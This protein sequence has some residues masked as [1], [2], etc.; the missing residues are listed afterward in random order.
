MKKALLRIFALTL[1][2][3]A[4]MSLAAC[5]ILGG[6]EETPG[7]NSGENSGEQGGNTEN[8]GDNTGNEETPDAHEHS[9]GEW[10]NAD[11]DNHKKTCECGDVQTE[12]HAWA[13]SG[14]TDAT[15]T[16]EGSVSYACACGATKSEALDKTPEH[17]YGEWVNADADNHKQTCECG[18]VQTEAHAWAESG[19]T[20]A[21]HTAEGSVSYACA[22]GATK[23]EALD[24][25]PE[26]S[27][28][29]WVNADEDNH[30]Q[31]CECG[32]V[33]TEAHTWAETDRT[34]ATHTAEGRVSYA[35]ACGATKSETL[36]K[37]PEHSYGEFE[38]L[39]AEN[40]KKTCECGDIQTEA[41]ELNVNDEC[42][43][44]YA[45]E[46]THK[47]ATTI[48]YNA[49]GHWY[50]SL[51]SKD[52]SCAIKKD[53]AAHDFAD[54]T[55]CSC[56]YAK[57]QRG[58]GDYANAG[59]NYTG[60]TVTDL[61]GAGAIRGDILGSTNSKVSLSVTE[62]EGDNA[63]TFS[64]QSSGLYAIIDIM[65]LS[66][67]KIV[68]ETD[69]YIDGSSDAWNTNGEIL[70]MYAVTGDA[71]TFWG[72]GDIRI[73]SERI[74]DDAG[75][76]I[77]HKYFI[78]T[79]NGGTFKY[80]ISGDKWYTLCLEREDISVSGSNVNIYLNGEKI[81]TFTHSGTTSALSGMKLVAKDK[82]QAVKIHFDNTYFGS[83][84]EC[85][86]NRGSGLYA[87]EAI[88]FN[89]T[90]ATQLGT[91]GVLSVA[92]D[93]SLDGSTLSATVKANNGN[94]ALLISNNN[95][96]KNGYVNIAASSLSSSMVFEADVC[97]GSMSSAPSSSATE[98]D[99]FHFYFGK[100]ASTSVWNWSGGSS[101][102]VDKT[103][104]ANF[105]Y[106][107]KTGK[108]TT[109]QINFDEWINVRVEFTD[110]TTTGSNVNYYVN[111]ELLCTEA[112]GTATTTENID[113]MRI[114]MP[115]KSGGNLY[116]DN[117]YYG[118]A[119]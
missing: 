51:C 87:D 27:Y 74:K 1:I 44:G 94:D 107:L 38:N 55:T 2:V 19:R 76:T 98:L 100:D 41:H 46:H 101:I 35:C 50:A 66:G 99:I 119:K 90:T 58:T 114:F 40:H 8:G 53:Y 106:Y 20:D 72:F 28:G 108:G 10:V 88:N 45:A 80:E 31:T 32:D 84:R 26:H 92:G 110:I 112:F 95:W 49:D 39:D 7:E 11:A 71:T 21:T 83:A 47:Y 105:K 34:D 23:S 56:G 5:S 118:A 37:T 69:F 103:D 67:N 104:E 97:F 4:I 15:H 111:G 18:D 109:Y 82:S 89:G 75:T 3:M 61:N 13:E 85:W 14:R 116:I 62:F 52:E 42:S 102:V 9:Y 48:S 59:L 78:Y 57:P 117:V 70:G 30:K 91:N 73:S 68:F 17:T 12:A 6:G 33:Q 22:C 54:G 77:G 86:G 81:Y 29:E 115:G 93:A 16:T 63:L 43:C 113:F 60:T 96:S 36:D 64:S 25:T 24:K 65:D 79:T